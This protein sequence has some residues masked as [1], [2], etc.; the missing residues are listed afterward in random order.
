MKALNKFSAKKIL[1]ISFISAFFC[2]ITAT[3][4]SQWIQT[5]GPQGSPMNNFAYNGTNTLYAQSDNYIHRTNNNGNS[6]TLLKCPSKNPSTIYAK[7]TMVFVEDGNGGVYRSTNSGNNWDSIAFIGKN[8]INTTAFYNDSVYISISGGVYISPD[9]GTTWSYHQQPITP[10][11]GN[12]LFFVGNTLYASCDSSN[13]FIFLKS[14]DFGRSFSNIE[15]NTTPRSTKLSSFIYA[16]GIFYSGFGDNTYYKSYDSCKT[17]TNISQPSQ[18][19]IVYLKYG[20]G[21]LFAN[22]SDTLYVSTD[23]GSTWTSISSF[24]RRISCIEFTGNRMFAGIYYEGV[25]RS[26]N[27]GYNWVA[28]N[29]GI[30]ELSVWGLIALGNYVYASCGTGISRTTGTQW[31]KVLGDLPDNYGEAMYLDSNILYAGVDGDLYR[32]TNNGT[33]WNLLYD[34]P[35]ERT[36]K[37]IY[38]NQ[39]NIY[40]GTFRNGLFISKDNGVTWSVASNES[41]IT[42]ITN[43]N[44]NIFYSTHSTHSAPSGKV[45]RSSDNGQTWLDISIPNKPRPQTALLEKHNGNI[46]GISINKLFKSTDLGLTWIKYQAAFEDSSFTCMHSDNGIL[47]CGTSTKS[48]KYYLRYSIDNGASFNKLG[49]S[50]PEAITYITIKGNYLY[51]GVNNYSVWRINKSL[52][53][54]GNNETGIT[55]VSFSLKQNYPNPFNPMCNVQFS[56]CNT[57]NVRIVVY[58]VQGREIETLVNEV[59]KPGTYEVSFDGSH[60]SSGVYFYKMITDGFTE[61]KKMLLI[62]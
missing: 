49:D 12:E 13:T 22:S 11:L 42:S 10:G 48:G 3:G 62:K 32:S 38:A 57:G 58:D 53:T 34:G 2:L 46:F 26:T 37:C 52:I 8:L 39:G 51:A 31:N 7:N 40:C 4:F 54:S 35:S 15:S 25:Y 33:N 56:M 20:T 16:N 60:Y 50:L 18:N 24:N 30:K 28:A 45:Y 9:R 61:T 44:G 36:I 1:V 17:W 55:P 43:L 21:K 59:L 27:G 19:S 6:W 29:N 23:E 5:N 47:Y 14:T 41:G